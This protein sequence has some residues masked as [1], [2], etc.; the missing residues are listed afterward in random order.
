MNSGSAK[1]VSQNHDID[2]DLQ[3]GPGLSLIVSLF[4][5]VHGIENCASDKEKRRIKDV[6]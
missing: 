3:N 6:I 4:H 5:L 1:A 2:A